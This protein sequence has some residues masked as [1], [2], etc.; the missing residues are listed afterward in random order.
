VQLQEFPETVVTG[1]VRSATGYM[2]A[3]LD[4]RAAM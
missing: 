3:I 2:M 4:G 1:N